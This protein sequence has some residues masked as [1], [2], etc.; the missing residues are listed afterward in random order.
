MLRSGNCLPIKKLQACLALKIYFLVLIVVTYRIVVLPAL[1]LYF[2]PNFSSKY[3]YPKLNHIR[4]VFRK[5][6]EE[7]IDEIDFM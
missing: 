2:F 4:I 6:C 5:K 3:F 7:F 1:I